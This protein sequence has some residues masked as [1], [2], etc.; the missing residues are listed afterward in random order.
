MNAYTAVALSMHRDGITAETIAEQLGLTTDEVTTMIT[1][2]GEADGEQPATAPAQDLTAGDLVVAVA[3]AEDAPAELTDLLAWGAAHGD[4]AVRDHAHA[5][6]A[7]YTAL[8]RRRE[9]DA[10]LELIT[11]E[12]AELE[13]RLAQLRE[14]QSALQ[15]P[16][17]ARKTGRQGRE[18]D[19]RVVR[20]W[21]K[22][23]GRSVPDRGQIPKH[24]LEDWRQHTARP[25]VAAG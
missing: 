18:Y 16:A 4:Q 19:P 17:K 9:V 11:A 8:R 24:V 5:A 2:H 10:E 21:A 23:H 1:T 22:Q 13:Q 12:A 6:A 20:A 25:L 14:R 3:L 7:A 15:P